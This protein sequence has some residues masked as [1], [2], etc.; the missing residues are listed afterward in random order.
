MPSKRYKVKLCLK[1][2]DKEVT[3]DF[4][5]YVR[6]PVALVMRVER[7]GSYGESNRYVNRHVVGDKRRCI[8]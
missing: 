6:L 1:I 3:R 2:D 5:T 4:T 8:S 7:W